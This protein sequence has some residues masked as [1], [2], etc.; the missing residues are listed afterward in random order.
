MTVASRVS[1][2]VTALA[3]AG[4]AT[5]IPPAYR[6]RSPGIDAPA[7]PVSV[8]A[9]AGTAVYAAGEAG[10]FRRDASGKW[11]HLA[12][13]AGVD[14]GQVT[15]LAAAGG[16]L[17]L[18]ARGGGVRLLREG[19]WTAITAADD[20]LPDDDVLCLA[21]EG[22][23]GGRLWAGTGTGFAVRGTDGKWQSFTPEDRWVG[24][25]APYPPP[26][27][28]E[29]FVL[30]GVEF[31]IE[32]KEGTAFRAPVTAIAAGDQAVV[33]GNAVGGLAFL[34]KQGGVAVFRPDQLGRINALL[35]DKDA[36]WAGTATGL[37]WAGNGG[38]AQGRPSPSWRGAVPASPLVFG[39]RDARPFA[40]RWF[41]VGYNTA[42]VVA[43]AAD[44]R[45]SLWVAFH[46]EGGTSVTVAAHGAPPTPSG[47]FRRYPAPAEHMA[48]GAEMP[49]EEYGSDLGIRGD[50]LS[51]AVGEEGAWLGNRKGL[52]L[53]R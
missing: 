9:A 3:L 42:P 50:P 10:L 41:Q 38:L 32:G 29:V 34:R 26:P 18:A 7:G 6:P 33:L 48:R 30:G 13:P 15:A 27:E 51:L 24:D 40:F 36:L 14:P 5:T 53:V 22:E 25:L 47:G 45:R 12:L 17:A 21:W 4:C 1:S 46:A 44:A 39:A 20:S 52:F 16:D 2:L 35:L 31:G 43:L 49:F 19:A 23:G 28:E 11:D 8:L 37:Y